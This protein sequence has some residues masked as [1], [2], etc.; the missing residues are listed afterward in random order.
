ML[1]MG[2]YP[3]IRGGGIAESR[4]RSAPISMM[5]RGS[6]QIREAMRALRAGYVL[7]A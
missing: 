2:C 5:E 6:I 1:G 4:E 7:L 3:L